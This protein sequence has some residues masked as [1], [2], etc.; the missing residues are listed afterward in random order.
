[1]I[2]STLR[3]QNRSFCCQGNDNITLSK[4]FDDM[5]LLRPLRSLGSLRLWRS[6]RF[7]MAVKSSSNQSASKFWFFEAKEAVE[8]MEASNV[9]L[10]VEVIEAT[11]I[12]ETTFNLKVLEMNKLMAKFTIFWCFEKKIFLNRMME[13][14]VKFCHL[15]RLGLWRTEMLFSTKSKDH[16]SKFRISWM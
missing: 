16:K 15:S 3:D 6:L 14:Q 8:V 4:F 7:L 13:F 12:F 1:M 11:E 9:I 5:R 10:S 2:H